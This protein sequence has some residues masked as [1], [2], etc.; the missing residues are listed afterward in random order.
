MVDAPRIKISP[1]GPKA[2][3]IIELDT[4]YLVTSTKCTPVV[5]KRAKG[6]VLE[7]VDGNTYLDFTSGVGVLN[8]GHSHPKV[9]NAVLNQTK[10]LVHFAGTDFYYEV[11]AKLAEKLAKITPGK[12][13]KKIFFTNSGAESNEAAIKAARWSTGRKQFVAL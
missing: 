12:F 7:D 11:Q 2:K 8:V 5:V 1:P 10:D 9:I 3:K 6:I 13:E 4:K